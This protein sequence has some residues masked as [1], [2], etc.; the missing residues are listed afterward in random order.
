[1][2]LICDV[3][4]QL[5]PAACPESELAQILDVLLDNAIR[6]TGAGAT[7]TLRATGN[8]HTVALRVEDNG[9]GLSA[10][11]RRRATRRF[12]RA[13]HHHNGA[14]T[15]TGSGLGL[16]IAERLLTTRNGQLS[17]Q[18]NQPHGLIVQ[19]TLPR[20]HHTDHTD[21]AEPGVS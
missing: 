19:A 12:W 14:G 16:A 5:H 1:V 11:E 3:P 10:A 17:V 6:Y 20:A 7:A 21:H 13:A 18:P 2:W 4:E 8:E 9:P 15:N